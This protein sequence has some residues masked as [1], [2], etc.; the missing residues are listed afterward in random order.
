MERRAEEIRRLVEA[1]RASGQS[2]PEFCREHGLMEKTFYVWRQR[3]Q[4]RNDRFARVESGKRIALELRNGSTIRFERDLLGV[5][6]QEL[7]R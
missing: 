7:S 4:K 2:V 5:V 6:L 3:V 1:Q